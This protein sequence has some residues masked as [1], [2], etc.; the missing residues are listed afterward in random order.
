MYLVNWVTGTK[1]I[2]IVLLVVIHYS[3]DQQILA[4]TSGVYTI[5]T[6]TFFLRLFPL[7]RKTYQDGQI[8][9]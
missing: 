1:L 7:V 9:P 4:L 3:A 8:D 2:F 5:S 6:A